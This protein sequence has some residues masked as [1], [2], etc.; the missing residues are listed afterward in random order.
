MVASRKAAAFQCHKNFLTLVNDRA[1]DEFM[2]TF[3]NL[4]G[5]GLG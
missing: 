5:L 2:E 4:M 3:P 1:S